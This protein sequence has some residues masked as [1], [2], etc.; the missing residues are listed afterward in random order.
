M[1]TVNVPRR[2][3][4]EDLSAVLDSQ[5]V[6][7]LIEV[8]E[9]TRW[10]GRPGYP[11]RTLGLATGSWRNSASTPCWTSASPRSSGHSRRPTRSSGGTWPLTPPTCPP[12]PTAN[13]S[14]PR[15]GPNASA[16]ATLMR[17]GATAPLSPPARRRVLRLPP[18]YPVCSKT[19]LP[20]AWRVV[21]AREHETLP[22]APLLDK[23]TTL[24]INP[25]TCALDKGYDNTR[26]YADGTARDIA[27]VIPLRQTPDVK[28]GEHN[29]PCCEHGE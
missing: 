19:D 27:P 12:T 22:A 11:L 23:L 20:L 24:G 16:T 26:V 6:A 28:R 5:E 15:T 14:C 2:S 3:A 8:L 18:P 17:P 1:T 4:V 7:A 10:T 9:A 29:P 25:E 21:T 13:A